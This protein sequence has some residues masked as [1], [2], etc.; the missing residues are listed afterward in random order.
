[1]DAAVYDNVSTTAY[2]SPTEPGIYAQH[3]PDDLEAAWAYA[4]AIHKEGRRIY[5]LDKTVD[6]TLKQE[7]ITE[8]EETYLSA[9]KQRYMGYHGVSSKNLM[10]HMMEKYGKFRVSDLEAFR[11]ALGDLIEVDCPIDVYLQR[12][13]DAIQFS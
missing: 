6:A 9:K 4:N 13:E 5:D 12:V 8:V 3:R 10:D 2:A 1:M 11:Q 7:I